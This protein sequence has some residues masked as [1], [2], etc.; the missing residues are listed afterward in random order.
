M[1]KK[2]ESYVWLPCMTTSMETKQALFFIFFTALECTQ[3]LTTGNLL[4]INYEKHTK[5]VNAVT[6]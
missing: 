1:Q 2:Y 4:K 3:G 5:S 6:Q